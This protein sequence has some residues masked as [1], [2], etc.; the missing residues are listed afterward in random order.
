MQL[1]KNSGGEV[2]M[3]N[4]IFFLIEFG[5]FFSELFDG[6]MINFGSPGY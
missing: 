5:S 3:V 2:T 1:E 6:K 4:T